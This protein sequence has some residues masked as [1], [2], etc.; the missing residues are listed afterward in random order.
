MTG[1]LVPQGSPLPRVLSEP[2]PDVV[3]LSPGPA[4]P[5]PSAVPAQA[6][7]IRRV[8]LE[9]D[10]AFGTGRTGPLLAGLVGPAVPLSRIEAARVGLLR[11]YRD[12]GFVLTTVSAAVEADGLLR[13]TVI[14]GRIAEVRLEGDIGP[15]GTLVLGFLR[16]LT[17][18]RPVSAAALERWLLL[19]QDVPGVSLNAV[20][21]PS[22]REPGALTLVA[23]VS[24]QA[25]SG[26]ATADNRAFR[27]TGPVEYLGVLDANS[28]TQLGERTEASVYRTDGNTQTFGQASTTAFIGTS[29]LSVRLYGGY[30]QS[31]PS[32]FLRDLSYSGTTTVFGASAS[33]PVI[34]SREQS[35]FVS[36][37]LDA[38]ETQVTSLGADPSA[39][40]VRA[41]DDLRIARV[42]ASYNL[43]DGLAGATRPAANDV[44]VRLSQG[45]PGLGT[46]RNGAAS[47][48]RPGERTDF[49]KATIDVQRVQTLFRPWAGATVALRGRVLG[50]LTADPLPPAEQ[51]FLGGPD[52]DRGF[53]SGQASGDNALAWT[54]ELDLNTGFEAR[55]LGYPLLVAAQFYAFYDRGETWQ[56]SHTQPN[57]RLSSEGIGARLTLTRY[58]E[59]DVEG[60]IRNTRLPSGTSATVSP[61]KGEALYWRVLTRF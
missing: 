44:S 31:G 14:E 22:E 25:F 45:L 43:Q 34:R 46:T 20:L 23:Q 53:Y 21:R 40:L 17:E 4:A 38:E 55:L 26:L 15:A 50:Q 13:F 3:P 52:Y 9:G 47:A 30:G 35:L 1:N 41:Q 57:Q 59:F 10:T 11:L 2:A 7:T 37:F 8:T 12:R 18:E 36:G 58:T 27:L 32:G 19:A 39:G 51:F 49:R 54:I 24:R 60:D 48:Q 42:G 28:F 29:G 16:H 5:A 61:I 6:A 33:Y 56:E